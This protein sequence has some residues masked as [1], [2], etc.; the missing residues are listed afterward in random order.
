MTKQ[1]VFST[2][3]MEKCHLREKTAAELHEFR[4]CHP[5]SAC[6]GWSH[7][8]WGPRVWNVAPWV[9]MTRIRAS[10]SGSGSLVISH[11]ALDQANSPARW[12]STRSHR[13]WKERPTI[14]TP[15]ALVLLKNGIAREGTSSHITMDYTGKFY[16]NMQCSCKFGEQCVASQLEDSSQ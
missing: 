5:K 2:C 7:P 1:C 8:S 11:P 4:W 3:S 9:R 12:L 14:P 15:L 10:N 6:P 13:L 16:P